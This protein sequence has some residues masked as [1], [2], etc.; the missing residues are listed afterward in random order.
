MIT[1]KGRDLISKY[2]LGYVPSYASYI[3]FGCGA[4][5]GATP[6]PTKTSMD[7]EMLRVPI[8]SRSVLVEKDVSDPTDP[9]YNKISFAGEIPLEDQYIITEVAVWSDGKDSTKTSDSRVLFAFTNDENWRISSGNTTEEIVFYSDPIS[10]VLDP[11]N[12]EGAIGIDDEIFAVDADNLTLLSGGRDPKDGARFLNKTIMVRGD[13]ET[14]GKK[15][16][17]D[18]RS[19]SLTGSPLDKLKFAFAL[20][21][22]DPANLTPL[23]TELSF[24][25]TFKSDPNIDS[26]ID[27]TDPNVEVPNGVAIW[28][29][30]MD[31][32][33]TP[34][35]SRYNVVST[36]IKDILVSSQS[37]IPTNL[38]YVEIEFDAF[39]ENWYA[40]ID[41]IRFDS[42][43]TT[44]P[45]YVMSG[46]TVVSQDALIKKANTNAYAEF[47]FGLD[48]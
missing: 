48:I 27:F 30:T 22:K 29:H 31:A 46:Y 25:M 41:A 10:G 2:L 39:D 44:N 28:R 7:F 3:S 5:P 33:N 26:N 20:Y 9:G 12:E 35:P 38:R 42:E 43:I 21:P 23:P 37:P 24:T 36:P 1:N 32:A 8:S 6:D 47:R 15:I 13:A 14:S 16:F 17:I 4:E 18:G 19:L 34:Q 40:G 11:I 45:L